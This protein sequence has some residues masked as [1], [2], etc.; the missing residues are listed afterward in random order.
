M[1]KWSKTVVDKRNKPVHEWRQN[2][3][4]I[5]ADEIQTLQ[6]QRR[7]RLQS[8]YSNMR[9]LKDGIFTFVGCLII[10]KNSKEK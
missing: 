8:M 1:R 10:L 6:H 9:E 5:P 2:K 4:S 3:G 7:V